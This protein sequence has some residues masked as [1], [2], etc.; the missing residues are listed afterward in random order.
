MFDTCLIVSHLAEEKKNCPI[1]FIFIIYLLSL[2]I[3]THMHNHFKV[4]VCQPAQTE[5]FAA[6]KFHCLHGPADS[7]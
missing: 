7:D 1:L 2:C 4:N 6:T 5:D 3:H